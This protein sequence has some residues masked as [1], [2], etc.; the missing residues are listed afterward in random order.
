MQGYLDLQSCSLVS[1]NVAAT[2]EVNF[3]VTL[4]R[5][6]KDV[7]EQRGKCARLGTVLR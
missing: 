6:L 7:G 1:M 5:R 4:C 2:E 3:A